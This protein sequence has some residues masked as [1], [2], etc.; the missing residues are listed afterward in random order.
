MP[1]LSSMLSA[2]DEPIDIAIDSTGLKVCGAGEWFINKHGKK[3]RS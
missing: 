3:H 2:T 1:E